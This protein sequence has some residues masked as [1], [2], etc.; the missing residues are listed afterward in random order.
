ML[1][2]RV[3]YSGILW[4]SAVSLEDTWIQS[5]FLL[6]PTQ[7]LSVVISHRTLTLFMSLSLSFFPSPSLPSVFPASSWRAWAQLLSCPTGVRRQANKPNM[8]QTGVNVC[9]C[10]C[11]CV[12]E[13]VC[14]CVGDGGVCYSSALLCFSCT[15]F[16]T[17]LFIALCRSQVAPWMPKKAPAATQRP[18]TS[19]PAWVLARS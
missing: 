13:C 6:S 12:C 4:H 14:V 7:L 2:I 3:R 10:M 5:S 1:S 17:E 19:H 11:V 8:S 9:V 16:F 15:W 18:L